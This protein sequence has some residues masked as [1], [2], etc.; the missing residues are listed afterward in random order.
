MADFGLRCRLPEGGTLA[1][2]QAVEGTARA[3]IADTDLVPHAT[4]DLPLGRP[5]T[6]GRLPT[7]SRWAPPCCS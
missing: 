4:F 7:A 2:S 1:R 6:P 3:G 5:P